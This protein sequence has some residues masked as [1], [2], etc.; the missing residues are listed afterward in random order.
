MKPKKL[1]VF[2]PPMC[3]S[4]GVCGPKVNPDLVRFSRDLGWLR[5]Q[6]VEVERFN[7]SS[8]PAAFAQQECVRE[9]LSKEGNEC[10]PL[11]LADGLIVSRGVYPSR[12][13]LMEF[14]GMDKAAREE[15][16]QD[17]AS[18]A[19]ALNPR[20]ETADCGPGCACNGPSGGKGIKIAISLIVL[21]AVIGA[22]I[23][24]V[25]SAKQAVSN[26]LAAG[27]ASVFAVA[28]AATETVPGTASQPDGMDEKKA[29]ENAAPEAQPAKATSKIGEYLGSL[30]DLNNVAVSQDAVFIF[31]PREKNEAVQDQTNNAVLAVQKTLKSNKVT[32]GL[33][34]LSTDS[35]DYSAISKQVQAPAILVATKGRGMAAVS[36]DVTESK[37]L[38]A[39]VASSSAGGCGPSGCGPSGAGCT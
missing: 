28:Q 31:I 5:K 14:A 37:L 1:Q 39:F 3:C 10:L 18:S 11:I 27:K 20:S 24:K 8:H 34:T 23:Y 16:S 7:L 13:E 29:V 15:H 33:Y 30:R 32:L 22:L 19:S 6:G 36:G 21:V 25:A 4:S 35:P 17:N 26:D 38:Q 2:D 9:A 12:S